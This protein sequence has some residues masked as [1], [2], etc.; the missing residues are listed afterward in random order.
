MKISFENSALED[1]QDWSNDK[2]VWKKIN[3]LIKSVRRTPYEG[4]GEPEPLKHELSGF[5]SRTI[6]RE[7]RFVYE[8]LDK[9]IKIISCKHHYTNL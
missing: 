4:I 9:E 2:K 3:D 7:H 8:V 6:V 5:W 1:Y